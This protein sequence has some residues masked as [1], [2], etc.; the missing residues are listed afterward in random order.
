VVTIL[1]QTF[2]LVCDDRTFHE[3]II[4]EVAMT[5]STLPSKLCTKPQH[6]LLISTL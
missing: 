4:V 5:K 6:A 1:L 3:R 2:T